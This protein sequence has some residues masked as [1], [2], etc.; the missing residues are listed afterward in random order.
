MGMST[1]RRNRNR[2][3]RLP[4]GLS[5]VPQQLVQFLDDNPPHIREVKL[6]TLITHR[7]RNRFAQAIL[8]IPALLFNL[9][10]GVL[11]RL[12]SQM[13]V[14]FLGVPLPILVGFLILLL[15]VGMMMSTFLG[16]LEGTLHELV[17]N[18]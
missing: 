10:L 15:V 9:A 6:A 7:C 3:L 17:P 8:L 4:L 11:S 18:G 14:F 2:C 16:Y 12:M 13:Q 1:K 5:G